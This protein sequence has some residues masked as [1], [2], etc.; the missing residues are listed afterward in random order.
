MPE[1]YNFAIRRVT[2]K[3]AADVAAIYNEGIDE[4]SAT[5]V[6][7]HFTAED[8]CHKIAEGGE[9]HPFL[10]A[11]LTGSE[12]IAGWVSISSYSPRSCYDGV[13]EVSVYITSDCRR[14]GIGEA[15]VEEA[16][17]A[18]ANAGYWKLMVRIFTFN[19]ASIN[20]FKKQGYV[21]A[22]LHKNH[23]KLDGKWLDVLEMEK[24]I[25]CN[26]K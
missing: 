12:R 15:L 4:R 9:K 22:G 2:F 19:K 20:L 13:G 23:G 6:T 3:D 16:F 21:E 25:P 7:T 11:E 18:A 14:Q 24:Q 1:R 10:I 8:I 17:D 26:L 5:F